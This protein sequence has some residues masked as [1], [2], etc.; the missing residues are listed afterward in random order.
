MGD[1]IRIKRH[2]YVHLLDNNTNVTRCIV[3][4]LVYTRKENE[5]CLFEPKPCIVIPPRCYCVVQ[6]PCVRDESGKPQLDE[7]NSVM[8]RMG[9]E[10][11][12][13]EQQPF[14]LEPG[15]ILKEENDEW[16]F[17]L[18]AIPINKGY[19]V[20]CICDFKDSARGLVRAGMEW[21]EEGP[22]TYIPRVEVKIIREVDAYTI[23]PNTALHL[24]ALVEFTDRNGIFRNAG[25][26][27]LHK[28]VGA[29]LPAVEEQ[30]LGIVEGI[31]LTET[32][33]IHLEARRTFTD[34]YG[35]IR[36]AGEQW[37]ITKDDSPV[38]IPD[39][40][41]KLISTVSAFVLTG[42]QCCII[43]NPVG[44]DGL[45]Q[46]G[47]REVRRGECSFFFHPGEKLIGGIES[48]RAI[49]EDEA[50]LL[51]AVKDF[52]ENGQ[53]RRA[54][55]TWMLR[56][57][58]EYTPD[59]NV[60]VLE[61]RSVIPLDKNEGIY[62]MDTRTG[63]VRAVIGSPYMLN[64]H[65]VLWE[66]HLSTEV[67]ELLASRN[68]CS[69]HIGMN[70]N[71]VSSRVRHL[72][73][74]FNVQHNAAVQIYDYKQ[75]K[76]RVVLGPNLVILSPD[77]EFTVLSLSGE[78]PK[79]PNVLQC[80]QLF[81][82][83]RFTSDSIVVE[84]SDHAR[85]QLNLS[86]NWYFDVDR[87][88]PDA[89]IFSVPDF[90]GDCCKTIASRVRGAVAA[91]DFD[92][93][94]RNS[95]RIIRE[96]VFGCNESGEIKD[97]LRFAANNLVVTNIDI[98]SVEPTDAKT[99]DSLQKSVQLAIEITTKSQEAA[100]RHGKER[101]DQEAKGKLERQKLLDKIEVERAKTKWLELQAESEAVQASGQSVAE[102]KA[103][104]ESLLI[105][106]ESEL[107]Q[108]QMRAKAYRITAE[109]E[110][111]KQKQKYDLELE[112]AK[113]QNELE[114][115]KA[116]QVAE[117]E[118]ERIRRTVNAIG[119]ETIVA[120]AQAGPEL[121]AKL[122]GGLGLKGYLITDGKS[123]VNLFNTAQ[124]M[125]GGLTQDRGT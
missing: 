113:R 41:E 83:P 103:K 44:N 38:H 124:G 80:L 11:I 74:R 47:K 77:E 109:S 68:G 18:K 1:I 28:T 98:Q 14:P 99:R 2:Y 125:L 39:V 31:I 91:E 46:F 119:R 10:E 104:A 121:Q 56:G 43:E 90:V 96:A 108:A 7:N 102:A 15:E 105:E 33:G 50:L 118:T 6:N 13:F 60:R 67:E 62:V 58:T 110:L 59:L 93:F 116:R 72:I 101:K 115:A 48:V 25:E 3:G 78:K 71:F 52:E 61:Q 19:H 66:K 82:G 84:T 86:Y 114:I 57:V 97:V 75:K 30:V 63:V 76:P 23:T 4:P 73:V 120:I 27:W 81:L 55:E 53:L 54:G 12:R 45:N 100:A 24:Q 94:H 85:L 21:M 34:V 9:M 123:P 89:K 36:K 69:K 29:Y 107:K 8:L 35:K 106:V 5:R 92:S 49:G 17:K 26:V 32:K 117:T 95:A 88:K 20:R 70:S 51:Q 64:E 65:E 79:R 111:K 16:L 87:K 122:L 37:L 42:K 112:F 22:K 40:H